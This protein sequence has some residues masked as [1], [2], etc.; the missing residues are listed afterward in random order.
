MPI[1]VLI[2][3]VSTEKINLGLVSIE[4]NPLERIRVRKQLKCLLLFF[5]DF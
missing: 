1:S 5:R 2:L 3:K 4:Y